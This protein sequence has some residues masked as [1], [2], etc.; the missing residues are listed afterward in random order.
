M[1][2]KLPI[3]PGDERLKRESFSSMEIATPPTLDA[4]FDA[5]PHIVVQNGLIEYIAPAL[6]TELGCD[7]EVLRGSLDA[8]GTR[9]D[10]VT[11][12]QLLN[13]DAPLRV[14]LGA[15]LLDRPV[16]LRRLGTVDDHTW[17]EVRSLANEF[18]M[19]SLL[20]RSGVGHMLL[21]PDIELLW[22]M[23]A[24]DLSD[25]FPGDNPLNWIELMDP[26]DMQAL[27]KAIYKVGRDPNLQRVVPHRLNADRTYTI[28]D[29]VESAMHD[30]DLRAVLVRS[31]LQDPTDGGV[32]GAAPYA[33]ITVSDHMPIGVVVAST[34]G[35]V[36]HRNAVAAKLIGARAGQS[37]VRSESLESLD[38]QSWMLAKLTAED[39]GRFQAVFDAASSP[40][41]Q[42]AYCTIPSPVDNTRWLRVSVSP[43]A[44]STIVMTIEDSTELAV[45]EQALRS[46]NRLL[47]A[48][49]S[50]SEEL[51]IVFDASG[52]VRYTSSSVHRML[53]PNAILEDST[54]FFRIV[55]SADRAV[56]L[57]LERRVRA[58]QSSRGSVDFRIETG[59]AERWHQANLT[60]LLDDADVQGLV[61]TVRD[62]HERYLAER[63]LNFLATHDVLT[64]LPDR[65]GLRKR[66]GTVLVEAEL[67]GHLTALM[68]CDIDNF[69]VINDRFG[70][71]AGDVVLTE[72][73]SR[74]RTALRSSDFVAR[75]G[76]DE[77]VVVVTN[78]DDEDH[79]L[80]L[81]ARV[82]S[83]VSGP[84]SVG[85]SS[86]DVSVSM[87]IA[88]GK[89][90][91]T[92]V[93]ELLQNADQAM[94]QSK[95]EGRGRFSLHSTTSTIIG[96][97][98]SE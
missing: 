23:S 80:A 41:G 26:D 85:E 51:V 61:L 39:A 47:E 98:L 65:G 13:G 88:L 30:P 71:H 20:R 92:S 74:L 49:D 12:D 52:R 97:R 50:H 32:K 4:L 93:D 62:I 21:S 8:I 63:E 83:S 33:G 37:V 89:G 44:A 45:A 59:S 14:R 27:G 19:E 35:T 31:R 90:G 36:L 95:R 78:V 84:V 79:A 94:Y 25:V 40:A 82:F 22:S 54:D 72:V 70:H 57:D 2:D 67:F 10:D 87:G 60:N 53:G 7:T 11:F 1:R 15:E 96:N 81:A 58:G 9:L 46:S 86:I 55:H 43:A 6:A 5:V 18:R 34:T 73:A 16:R 24:A 76:G 3:Q 48:L 64:T 17:I 28:I 91:S 75:F 77:F 42:S 69:K 38:D 29:T 56:V 66:L 68:F